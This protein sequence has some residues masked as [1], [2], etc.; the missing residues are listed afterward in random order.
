MARLRIRH[1][2]TYI[3]QASLR[4]PPMIHRWKIRRIVMMSSRITWRHQCS[5]TVCLKINVC[6]ELVSEFKAL[7]FKTPCTTTLNISA[8]HHWENCLQFLYAPRCVSF[9]Y[10]PNCINAPKKVN[11]KKMHPT[12]F[13]FSCPYTNGI[14]LRIII[15]DHIITQ[16][17]INETAL[18]LPL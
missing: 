9:F 14:T 6:M 3:T 16:S 11:L 4:Q 13:Y 17:L 12:A 8:V 2:H 5:A 7:H 18:N 15:K 1:V 10:A